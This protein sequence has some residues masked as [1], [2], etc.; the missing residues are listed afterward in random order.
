VLFEDGGYDGASAVPPR[1]TWRQVQ[2]AQVEHDRFYHAD[3]LGLC[4]LDQLRHY[5]LHVAKLAGAVAS[6]LRGDTPLDDL[7]SRRVPDMII[8]GVKL[9]TVIGERLPD[10]PVHREQYLAFSAPSHRGALD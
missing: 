9:A 10:E 5:A 6:T 1:P 3:V 7:L 2:L 4:K 8:F